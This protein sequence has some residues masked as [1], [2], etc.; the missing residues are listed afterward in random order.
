MPTDDGHRYLPST[1]VFL[2]E[3]LKLALCLIVA[4]YQISSSIPRSMPT[5][6]IF[7]ALAYATFAGDS[8]KMAVP[9]G[10]YT[11]ANNL[12]Y[13]GISNLD[14]ATYQV[15]YQLKIIFTAVFSVM[16]LKKTL[17][18]TQ[19]LALVLLMF[20]VATVSLPEEDSSPMASSH[21]T[22]VYISGPSGLRKQLLGLVSASG[23]LKKRSATYEGIQEDEL[24]LDGAIPDSS[25]GLAAALAV[26]IISGFAGV[27]FEK[28]LKDSTKHTSLWIRNLQM[29]L[30]SLFPA[31]FIGVLFVDGESV[32]KNGFFDGYNLVV[33][34]SIVVQAFGGIL[35]AF[36]IFYADNISKNFAISISMVLSSLASFFF[37]DLSASPSVS[38]KLGGILHQDLLTIPVCYWDSRCPGSDLSVWP[39]ETRSSQTSCD[40]DS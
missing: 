15:V 36:C 34:L 35:V 38:N 10:L 11:L 4:L 19:W 6:S 14:A 23:N 29:S 17:S 2:V 20:G 24:A 16:L 1:A 31:F 21:H 22:R 39:A 5:T 7:S 32:A 12:Q 18:S 9:A 30:Y 3:L 26:C 37:F 40:P 13:L 8:W 27:Y 28:V 25:V 33:V